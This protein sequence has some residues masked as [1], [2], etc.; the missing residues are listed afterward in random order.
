[1]AP[2]QY[3]VVAVY[4][5]NISIVSET[6]MDFLFGGG[7][8]MWMQVY[9]A[10]SSSMLTVAVAGIAGSAAAFWHGVWYVSYTRNRMYTSACLKTT[11][12]AFI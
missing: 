11:P 5:R 3:G 7:G 2:E 6:E 8:R 9:A 4:P 1:M 12:S 10:S